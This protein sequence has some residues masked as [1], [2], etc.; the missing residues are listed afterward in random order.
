MTYIG[1]G[2]NSGVGFA[3]AKELAGAPE[4]FRVILT[5]RSLDKIEAAISEIKASHSNDVDLIALHLD[6]TVERSIQ[7]AASFVQDSYGHLDV[8]INNAGVQVVG[9]DLLTIFQATFA[10]NVTGPALVSTHFRSLLLASS[11]PYSIYLS[12]ETGSLQMITDPTS[13]LRITNAGTSAYRASKS[14]LNMLAMHEQL[15]VLDTGLKV[16][17]LSPGLVVSNLR[18]TSEEAR[19]AY[20]QAGDP[21]DSARLVLSVIRGERDADIGKLITCSGTAPW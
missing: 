19:S 17:A 21:A 3:I 8:L 18:G 4:G 6:V 11:A 1:I 9:P 12:S 14:A 5:G 15:E 2:A 10:T 13:F 7:K 20:G 16:V